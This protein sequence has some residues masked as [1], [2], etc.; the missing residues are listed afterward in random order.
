MKKQSVLFVATI[1]AIMLLSGMSAF[2]AE[3]KQDEKG[4]WV[5]NEDGSYLVNQW[6][7]SPASG[8][9][10]YMGS[11]GYMLT[12]TTTPDGYY[13]NAAG[14][15]RDTL[16]KDETKETVSV[17]PT[18]NSNTASS[19]SYNNDYKTDFDKEIEELYKDATS[20]DLHEGGSAG[21]GS[22]YNFN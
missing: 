5:E 11:D 12:N 3:W 1:L 20:E 19:S 18:T 22:F 10:Y 2:A 6:Y 21:G 9:W 7:Q 13:V 16:D 14:E 8:L 17:Q 4:W 15:W